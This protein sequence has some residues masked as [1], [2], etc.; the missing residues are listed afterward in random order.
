MS[1]RTTT[2]K[3]T[4]FMHT[5]DPGC[6]E[7]GEIRG[8][9]CDTI[10]QQEH[11]P[12]M[13]WRQPCTMVRTTHVLLCTTPG[14]VTCQQPGTGPA[15]SSENTVWNWK[16]EQT[17]ISQLSTVLSR[18]SVKSAEE[19]GEGLLIICGWLWRTSPI[20]LSERSVI[21][22]ILFSLWIDRHLNH[23]WFPCRLWD[24]SC[25]RANEEQEPQLFNRFK[26]VK[27]LTVL[28][29]KSDTESCDPQTW[30]PQI[31]IHRV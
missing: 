8:L 15:L 22:Q 12:G 3:C 11:T 16:R 4:C 27:K 29:H 31:F 9:H 20:G 2:E 28:L 10:S 5:P 30:E 13:I 1:T 7:N 25:V 23:I 14:P 6:F 24:N 18:S 17:R 26:S 19:P 21:E